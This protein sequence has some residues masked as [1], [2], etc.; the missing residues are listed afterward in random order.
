M[1]ISELIVLSIFIIWVAFSL[2]RLILPKIR[3]GSLAKWL[4]SFAYLFPI[5]QWA[6]F[7]RPVPL[8]TI[9]FREK[10]EEDWSDWQVIEVPSQAS[11]LGLLW[12]PKFHEYN[13]FW[14]TAAA[15]ATNQ[16]SGLAGKSE[17]TSNLV[18]NYLLQE[19]LVNAE[20][21]QLSINIDDKDDS[22]I[23]LFETTE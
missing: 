2:I 1:S 12:N 3:Y 23:S 15:T 20:T 11:P 17:I 13:G 4:N 14:Q 21:F 7:S 19:Q 5:N 6:L 9:K 10:M 8:L 22:Y 18:A 16:T